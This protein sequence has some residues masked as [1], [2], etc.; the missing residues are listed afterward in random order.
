VGRFGWRL[1][2]CAVGLLASGCDNN[3]GK[4]NRPD[5]NMG[6][7]TGVVVC[8][9]TGRPARF[10][11]VALTR[12]P[13]NDN[14]AR[15]DPLTPK[16]TALT[17]LDGRFRI[18]AVEPGR[19]YAFALL[20]GYLDPLAGLDMKR[21]EI[22]PNDRARN[23]DAI[24]QWKEHMSAITVRARHTSDI[25]LSLDRAAEISGRVMWEDGSPAIGMHFKLM[26]KIGD[27]SWSEVGMMMLDNYSLRTMSDGRGRYRIANLPEG[28]YKICALLPAYSEETSANWCMG[29]TYRM[30][31]AEDI[32]V[33]AGESATGAD[34]TIPI[35]GMHTLAGTVTSALD[36]RLLNRGTVRL[37]YADDRELAREIDIGEDGGFTFDYVPEDGFILQVTGASE[38]ENQSAAASAVPAQ[39]SDPKPLKSQDYE[40]KEI[41]FDVQDDITD[42][43]VALTPVPPAKSANPPQATT[44]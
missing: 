18:E 12:V 41:R 20:G 31:D 27:K 15:S 37:L 29:D 32:K 9:D 30:K 34:I 21:L 33:Q 43:K 4:R 17:N 38:H 13:R 24:Q 28:N 7:V 11:T 2:L 3:V 8:T 42:L 16:E 19:Y 14:E 40:D 23:L 36:G 25:S 5:A 22:L 10:A 26:R 35:A 6:V 1:L 44:Q 39:D